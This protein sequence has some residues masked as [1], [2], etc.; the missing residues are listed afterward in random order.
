MHAVLTNHIFSK[1]SQVFQHNLSTSTC[2]IT[3]KCGFHF[4]LSEWHFQSK[5]VFQAKDR[6]AKM[7]IYSE[8]CL[9][10]SSHSNE[11]TLHI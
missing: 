6:N 11:D 1:H 9:Q 2:N 5:P 10:S 3:I 7:G 4:Q 8:S